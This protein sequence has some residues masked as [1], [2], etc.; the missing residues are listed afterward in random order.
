MQTAGQW[1]TFDRDI[2][3]ALVS[4]DLNFQIAYIDS[5]SGEVYLVGNDIG[6]SS[7][8]VNNVC[9]PVAKVLIHASQPAMV[10]GD[11]QAFEGPTSD[12]IPDKS[13]VSSA[14]PSPPTPAAPSTPSAIDNLAKLPDGLWALFCVVVIL[15]GGA[16]LACFFCLKKKKKK[17]KKKGEEPKQ[18]EE[19]PMDDLTA[20][21]VSPQT[22]LTTEWLRERREGKTTRPLPILVEPTDPNVSPPAPDSLTSGGVEFV[23]PPRY[24]IL[25]PPPP[26]TAHPRT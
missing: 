14:L 17:K 6:L 3:L 4:L 22:A 19:I 16:G 26:P 25:L 23:L 12:V 1:T 2:R 9:E 10:L 24:S 18:T 15:L 21:A 20:A 13:I 5:P 11:I 8:F 7:R